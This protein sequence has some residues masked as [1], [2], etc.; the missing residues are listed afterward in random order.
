[1]FLRKI[2]L[3]RMEVR[4]GSWRMRLGTRIAGVGR[5]ICREPNRADRHLSEKHLDWAMGM[6]GEALYLHTLMILR[7][8]GN[9]PMGRKILSRLWVGSECGIQIGCSGGDWKAIST[10]RRWMYMRGEFAKHVLVI[11]FGIYEILTE[12]TRRMGPRKKL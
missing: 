12:Y 3:R 8:R 2:R 4:Q 11:P 5:K 6:V 10:I 7:N 1:M 9:D